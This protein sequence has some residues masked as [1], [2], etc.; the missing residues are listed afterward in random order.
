MLPLFAVPTVPAW[1]GTTVLVVLLVACAGGF[2]FSLW[3]LWRART[4]SVGV[5]WF[6]N[7][8]EGREWDILAP[9]MWTPERDDKA[10]I[11]AMARRGWT[12]H[13]MTLLLNTSGHW[14]GCGVNG[15]HGERPKTA[16]AF[17]RASRLDDWLALTGGDETLVQ[18]LL[19]AG[20]DYDSAAKAINE[21]SF[22]AHAVHTLATLRTA[23]FAA[24]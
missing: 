22:D 23:A 6:Y 11:H 15:W 2:A 8:D 12:P 4:Q 21:P 17:N 24:I 10:F 16:A 20:F 5:R 18:S 9:I 1:V 13:T 3:L 14:C 7:T 19:A